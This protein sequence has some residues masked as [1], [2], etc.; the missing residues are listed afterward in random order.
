MANISETISGAK[1]DDS[2]ITSDLHDE[3]IDPPRHMFIR[4]EG[5]YVDN[6]I[7]RLLGQ[8]FASKNLKIIYLPNC[9]RDEMDM[10]I[11]ASKLSI[12]IKEGC[13]LILKNMEKLYSLL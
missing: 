13:I 4:T 6:Y 11:I 8:E 3:R 9:I 5:T 2:P 10:E 12:W 1:L 7:V